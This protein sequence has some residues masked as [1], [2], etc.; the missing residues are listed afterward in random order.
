MSH[1]RLILNAVPLLNLRTGIG[2]YLQCLYTALEANH[3]H[4]WEIG[5]FDGSRVLTEIPSG[6]A[7]LASWSLLTELFWKLP[8]RLGLMVRMAMQARRERAFLRAARGYDVYHEAGFF[9]YRAPRGVKTVFTIHDMSILRHPE[10]HPAERVLF[11]RRGLATRAGFADAVLTVSEFSKAEIVDCLG[12][13]P[14]SI[15][16]TPLAPDPCFTRL[17]NPAT[18]ESLRTRYALPS[19]YFLFVGSGDPRKNADVIPAALEA[20]GL[21]IPLVS[22]GWSGW[23]GGAG[24]GR[25]RTLGYVPDADLPGIYSQALALVFPSAYEGFGLPVAEAMACG[26]PVITAR[27]A[28][29]SEVGGEAAL[30]LDHPRDVLGLASLLTSLAG[31]DEL[32][33]RLIAKGLERARELVWARTADLTSQVFHQVLES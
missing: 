7:S 11:M 16:V 6:P 8:P 14:A 26:C 18:Q 2:R 17:D 4:Q 29:L 3:G 27:A 32:R 25:V 12:L 31:D 1:N 5:Y 24:Q 30:Y 23:S 28:S 33:E 13:D 15:T 22:V 19:R 9:P 10:H 21:D 20:S